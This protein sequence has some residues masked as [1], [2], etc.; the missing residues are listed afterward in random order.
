M[1]GKIHTALAGCGLLPRLHL[2]DAGYV[3]SRH[4]V[5]AQETHGVDLLGPAPMD[6]HWQA[7]AGAGFDAASFT[8]DWATRQ[9]T[10]P[11][12]HPSVKWSDTHDTRAQPIVNIRFARADCARCPC[13]AQCTRSADGPREITVRPEAQYLALQAARA[14]QA[15]PEFAAEYAARAGIEGTLSLGL[16]ACDLRRT[17]YVGLAKTHLGHICTAAA[18]N[19]ARL[20]AWFAD[21]PRARTRRSAFAKLAPAA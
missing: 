11:E 7:R 15:T 16:R 8:L 6:N 19:V 17:R 4:L 9:A 12:G 21:T 3:A 13:R 20:A 10:C 2:V 5:T 18:L 1:T 14:R